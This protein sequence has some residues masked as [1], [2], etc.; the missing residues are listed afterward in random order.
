MI[1]HNCDQGSHEWHQ[2][3]LGKL[4]GSRLKKMFAKDNLSLIDELIAEEEV[5]MID[6]DD[7]VSEE[8]QR[9]IDMDNPGMTDNELAMI[10]GTD[11]F[12]VRAFR[13][14]MGVKRSD[15]FLEYCRKN[16]RSYGGGR[17]VK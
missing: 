9:G 11:K 16:N 7:F 4:T 3:R 10:I 1:I 15:Q 12:K 8:M 17:P 6:D 2:L 5:G 14:R 13:H